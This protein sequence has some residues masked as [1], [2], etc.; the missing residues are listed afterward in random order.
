MLPRFELP[1]RLNPSAWQHFL[2][3]ALLGALYFA[4]WNGAGNL[5]GKAF[6]IV[7]LGLFMLWQPFVHNDHRFSTTTLLLG[8]FLMVGALVSLQ[9]WILLIWIM[10]LTAIIGGKVS[11]LRSRSLHTV[12]LVAFA[13]LLIAL[14]LIAVPL[15]IPIA[16]LPDEITWLGDIGLLLSILIMIPLSKQGG[17][18]RTEGIIDFI[19]SLIVILILA[20]L[21]LGS[22]AAMLTLGSVYVI[23]LLQ[24]MLLMGVILLVLG[25][26]WDPHA[27]FAGF[28]NLF[29]RYLM[30]VGLPIDRWLNILADLALNEEDP[31]AFLAQACAEMVQWLP[32]LLGVAWE[33]D[34]RVGIQGAAEGI[35]T[36]FKYEE[37]TLCIYT[38]HQLSA[39]LIFHLQLPAK[40]LAKF[41]GDK[42][43]D[44]TL[45]KMFYMK[46]IHE[47]GARLTHDVKNM[48][49]TINALCIA[50]N[51]QDAEFSPA[52]Q[53]LLRRQ[54]P[55]IAGR[56]S[57]TLEKLN[58]P[59]LEV[60]KQ[61]TPAPRWWR[62]FNQLVAPSPW[63][64]LEPSQ[65]EGDLSAELFSS[66]VENL[67]RNASEKRLRDPALQLQVKLIDGDNGVE[68]EVS[69]NGEPIAEDIAR[70]LFSV[71]VDSK[72]G[73]GIGLY[74]AARHAEL[75][76]YQLELSENRLGRVCFRLVPTTLCR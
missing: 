62:D 30:S 33:A 4:L 38:R 42:K 34:G 13:S 21:I 17:I 5:S 12:Y 72:S 74:Q 22:L 25:W 63:I 35:C 20:A 75:T 27:G 76:G 54:L 55:A 6:F 56:L 57:G 32:W 65:A 67:M 68:L 2:L 43:R 52:Y 73:L 19:N 69:D 48:L 66:V 60:Q 36:E 8:L 61:L 59:K 15:A 53:A 10:I 14:L 70:N 41:Y 1:L 39:T 18:E 7:H 11:L 23:A 28:G 46:A 51:E 44:I 58:Q 29:S 45:K 3:P 49:Q 31:E 24:S 37:V 64:A 71:P 40:L 50:S 9:G 26:A 47:T 16:K